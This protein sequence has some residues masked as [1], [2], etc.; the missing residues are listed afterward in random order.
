MI[1]SLPAGFDGTYRSL[2]PEAYD[3]GFAYGLTYGLR[4]GSEAPKFAEGYSGVFIG[5]AADA[6]SRSHRYSAYCE[7][8]GAGVRSRNAKEREIR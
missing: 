2:H 1:A 8:Y 5:D 4:P 7:G 6:A 3:A